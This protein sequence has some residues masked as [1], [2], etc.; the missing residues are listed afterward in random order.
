MILNF[1]YNVLN[2]SSNV[3]LDFPFAQR[4]KR[5]IKALTLSTTFIKEK[6]E[7]YMECMTNDYM[8]SKQFMSESEDDDDNDQSGSDN[9]RMY[10]KVYS[11]STLP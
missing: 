9:E 4:N 10:V 5:Q 2:E 11:I 3:F 6:N 7:D 8:S 1:V